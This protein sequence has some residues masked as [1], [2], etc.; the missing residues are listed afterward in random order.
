MFSITSKEALDIQHDGD[1]L[2]LIR[3]DRVLLRE[4]WLLLLLLELM[5]LDICM[6]QEA[7]YSSDG[8]KVAIEVEVK[9]D[10][11]RLLSVV[12]CVVVI[13]IVVFFYV[14]R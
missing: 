6:S 11:W 3:G 4:W 5:M 9:L 2:Y 8:N 14:F 1:I 7:V 13:K 12:C 10:D